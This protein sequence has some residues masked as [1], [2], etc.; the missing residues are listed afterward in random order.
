MKY[1]YIFLFFII[2]FGFFIIRSYLIAKLEDNTHYNF[3]IKKIEITP[4][5]SMVFFDSN[6]NKISPHNFLVGEN[7]DVKVGDKIIKEKNSKVLKIYRKNNNGIYEEH[8]E[9]YS[10]NI[11]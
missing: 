5:H 8:L 2:F 6:N 1:K 9:I 10:N 11:L 4:V 3:V 7:E